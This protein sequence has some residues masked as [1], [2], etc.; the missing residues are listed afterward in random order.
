MMSDDTEAHSHQNI[1]HNGETYIKLADAAVT[2]WHLRTWRVALYDALT[3]WHD[4][5]RDDETPKAALRRL[6][7][8]EILAALDP[9]ISRP[10]ADLVATA[11]RE[12]MKDAAR[13][14]I[15]KY[16]SMV[17][18]PNTPEAWRLSILQDLREMTGE[19]PNVI[20]AADIDA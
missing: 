2:F 5:P 13:A 18:H 4:P 8:T 7:H 14:L 11:R 20:T 16:Q 6:V 17:I 19:K 9:A 12:G 15:E 1:Q 10:A 3:E